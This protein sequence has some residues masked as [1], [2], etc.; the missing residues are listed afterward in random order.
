MIEWLHEGAYWRHYGYSIN[1]AIAF[2]RR[3]YQRDENP[4]DGTEV[5]PSWGLSGVALSEE[6][7]EFAVRSQLESACRRIGG[8]KI[9]K[10]AGVSWREFRPWLRDPSVMPVLTRER[11][12][13]A[14]GID[15]LEMIRQD[16]N[17][18]LAEAQSVRESRPDLAWPYAVI[19]RALEK[20]GR[21]GD[22]IAMYKTGAQK[23]GSSASFTMPWSLVSESD[24]GKFALDRLLELSGDDLEPGV[25]EYIDATME[26]RTRK[27]WLA[28]ADA[29]T[30][31]KDYAF[32]YQCQYAAG[33]DFYYSNDIA[34]IV[35]AIRVSAGLAD[36]RSLEA[37]AAL[38]VGGLT[39]R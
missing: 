11:L 39:E 1:Q 14:L 34:E 35:E 24:T 38:H 20:Q 28:R 5:P 30:R 9:A 16:L 25:R 4:I 26:R 29:A 19:G 18:A 3:R 10:F 17:A 8:G 7:C 33:W 21:P 15:Q 22:A 13:V 2:D 6:A 27:F 32:A 12:A 36:F 31:E 37:I 23:L